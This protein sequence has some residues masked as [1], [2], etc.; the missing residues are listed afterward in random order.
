[1]TDLATSG[2]AGVYPAE[3]PEPKTFVSVTFELDED[4][5]V[6]TDLITKVSEIGTIRSLN[7]NKNDGFYF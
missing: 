4:G 7:V 3:K 2:P 5:A 6:L 1:M